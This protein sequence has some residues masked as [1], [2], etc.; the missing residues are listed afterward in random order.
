MVKY[1]FNYWA[2]YLK[3]VHETYDQKKRIVERICYN[4]RLDIC[5]IHL[6]LLFLLSKKYR[7]SDD[8]LFK[9]KLQWAFQLISILVVPALKYVS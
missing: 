2:N 8:Y 9:S 3:T 4:I 7:P 5:N 6:D 1:S